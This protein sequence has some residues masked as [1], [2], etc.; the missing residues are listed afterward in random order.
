MLASILTEILPLCLLAFFAGFIDSMVGGGGMIQLPALLL[1][2]PQLSLAQALATNK[3]A[4][5][6]GTVVSSIH[7]ALRLPLRWRR[8]LYLSILA[9]MGG[10]LGAYSVGYIQKETFIPLL[11]V[12]L[13]SVYAF[14][15]F[16]RQL[17]QQTRPAPPWVRRFPALWFGLLGL[18][19]GYYE[20]LI[21]PGT[22]SLLVIGLVVLGGTDFLNATG[23]AKIINAFASLGALILFFSFDQI[24]W[25]LA[26]PMSL[27]NMAGNFFGS[28]LAMHKGSGFLRGVFQIILILLIL[29]LGYAFWTDAL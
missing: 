19:L 9:L 10:I 2:Q 4:S 17:G 12:L 26:V 6:L 22:G 16:H 29:R 28:R 18:T 11:L 21:G 7:Y 5:F 23:H 15:H 27:F 8:T 24:Y 1:W 3:T 25:Q 20:G 14:V 13:I